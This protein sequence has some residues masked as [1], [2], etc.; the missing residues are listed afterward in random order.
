MIANLV[1]IA[2][3]LLVL[4]VVAR[5]PRAATRL[6]GELPPDQQ[7]RLAAWMGD[8]RAINDAFGEGA[9]LESQ[10][11]QPNAS[12]SDQTTNAPP[13]TAPTHK[14]KRRVRSSSS[15]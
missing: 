10:P 5:E 8:A 14:V 4:T 7:L 12:T 6:M 3:V 13:A 1:E 2:I 9:A 15:H 11:G